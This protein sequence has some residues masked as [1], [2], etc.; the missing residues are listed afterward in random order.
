[1]C[2]L[3]VQLGGGGGDILDTRNSAIKTS[4]HHSYG[5]PEWRDVRRHF[6][7]DVTRRISGWSRWTDG[8]G[9]CGRVTWEGW[10]RGGEGIIVLSAIMSDMSDPRVDLFEMNRLRARYGVCM[11]GMGW[12]G[13]G[14]RRRVGCGV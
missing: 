6:H 1:M 14:I 2:P 13:G 4:I 12:R 7:H 10:G 8:Q 5:V 11:W 9:D 3:C